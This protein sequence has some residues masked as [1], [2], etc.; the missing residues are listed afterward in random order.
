MHRPGTAPRHLIGRKAPANRHTS[1][2]GRAGAY[3]IFDSSQIPRIPGKTTSESYEYMLA[4]WTALF[5]LANKLTDGHG[6]LFQ[7]FIFLHDDPHHVLTADELKNIVKR[8]VFGH[9]THG[10]VCILAPVSFRLVLT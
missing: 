7:H 5:V 1:G 4:G 10:E 6:Q 3:V 9:D 2:W 8:L